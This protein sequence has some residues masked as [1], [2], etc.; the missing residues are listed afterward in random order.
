MIILQINLNCVTIV[1]PKRYP[2]VARQIDAPGSSTVTAQLV[3]I[4]T[5]D[6]QIEGMNPRVKRIQSPVDFAC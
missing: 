6:L 1:K 4:E 2:P 3:Q 5:W